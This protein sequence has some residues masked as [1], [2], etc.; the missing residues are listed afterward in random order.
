[1]GGAWGN[2]H[3]FKTTEQT[4]LVSNWIAV[5]LSEKEKESGGGGGGGR[6]GRARCVGGGKSVGEIYGCG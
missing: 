3:L 1:M 4:Q 6:G 2:R 5:S